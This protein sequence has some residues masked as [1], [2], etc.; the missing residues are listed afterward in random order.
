[1]AVATGEQTDASGVVP[2][3]L[4]DCI[5]VYVYTEKPWGEDMKEEEG[6]ARHA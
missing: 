3:V 6:Q 2:S 4:R 1:M 5:C